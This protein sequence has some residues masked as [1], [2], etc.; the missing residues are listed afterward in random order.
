MDMNKEINEINEINTR[1]N[2]EIGI[3]IR[4]IYK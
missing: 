1:I 2:N 4:Q 3:Y